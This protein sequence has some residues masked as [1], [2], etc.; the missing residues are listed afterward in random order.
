MLT[1]SYLSTVSK[2]MIL[3]HLT[4][5]STMRTIRNNRVLK[6]NSP[7]T[8]D[9]LRE[10]PSDESVTVGVLSLHSVEAACPTIHIAGISDLCTYVHIVTAKVLAVSA[11]AIVTL[12]SPSKS[13]RGAYLCALY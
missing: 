3:M 8:Q 10:W 2:S 12:I 7:G 6:L 9:F 11:K 1:T 5:Y 4:V 13:N